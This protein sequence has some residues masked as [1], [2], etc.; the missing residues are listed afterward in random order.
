MHLKDKKETI[1]III[2]GILIVV[3]IALIIYNVQRKR[4]VQPSLVT[5]PVAGDAETTGS[6]GIQNS[7]MALEEEAK[8]LSLKRDPFAA[9]MDE[10]TGEL[11]LNG[12]AWD[13][14]IPR[15]IINNEILEVGG[16]IQGS[17]IIEIKEDRVILN[18][19][20][21]NMELKLKLE[22]K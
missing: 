2:T 7:F 21:D 1:Q 11:Y 9:S 10:S 5:L 3:L 6:S 19:G 8:K 17:T 12:I 18:N 4:S 16:Q 13:E 22:E 20:K 14:Q 15:A